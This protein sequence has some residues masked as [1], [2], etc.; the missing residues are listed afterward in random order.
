MRR[1]LRALIS[2][3]K[4]ATA[5][6]YGLVVSLI[7]LAWLSA[8]SGLADVTVNMW[9]DVAIKVQTSSSP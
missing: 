6:E 4:A 3:R 1:R 9:D 5:V 8:F 7:V 2:N